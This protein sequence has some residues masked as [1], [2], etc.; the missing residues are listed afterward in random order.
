MAL[1][2]AINRVDPAITIATVAEFAAVEAGQMVATVK[3][4]PFAVKAALVEAVAATGAGRDDIRGQA[5]PA[6]EGRA[7]PDSAAGRQGQRARQDASRSPKRGWRARAAG[8][9]PNGARRMTRRT[10]AEALAALA[11][12]NDMVV[13][14]GASAMSDPDDVMPAAIRRA[15]GEVIRTGMPVDPGNLIVVGS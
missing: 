8:S 4:I 12:D 7:D 11:R 14:F 6:D 9:P 10:V 5:V 13:M 3:I 15:G 2:D 1:I